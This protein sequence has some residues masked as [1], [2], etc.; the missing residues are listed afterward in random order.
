MPGQHSVRRGHRG[1]GGY[2]VQL[3]PRWAAPLVAAD[4]HDGPALQLNIETA[5]P[6]FDSVELAVGALI[7]K[8]SLWHVSMIAATARRNYSDD[9]RRTRPPFASAPKPSVAATTSRCSGA[10]PA[11][12][13][14]RT[15]T[16]DS[17]LASIPKPSLYSS[18]S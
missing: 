11:R 10:R 14:V 1:D 6:I 3:A 15:S 9:R 7:S 4:L 13:H 8:P 18:F 5:L 17:D 2:V 16:C 12:T